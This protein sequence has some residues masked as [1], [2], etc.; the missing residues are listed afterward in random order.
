MRKR[1]REEKKIEKEKDKV[2]Q[3]IKERYG[4]PADLKLIRPDEQSETEAKDEWKKGRRGLD[5]K[6]RRLA[7]DAP[8]VIPTA[9]S[10][11]ASSTGG[12]SALSALRLRILANSARRVQP[13]VGPLHT[14]SKLS[15]VVTRRKPVP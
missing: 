11:S 9:K 3:G 15:G 4:L 5:L 1:F 7:M 2:D 12:S 14:D 10:G 13:L 6:R 8:I